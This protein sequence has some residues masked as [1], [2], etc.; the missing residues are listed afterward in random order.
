MLLTPDALQF[1][2]VKVS[3]WIMWAFLLLKQS[4]QMSEIFVACSIQEVLHYVDNS[5]QYGEDADVK[6]RDFDNEGADGADEYEWN[7][8]HRHDMQH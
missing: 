1:T 3:I 8:C 2:T 6:I 5:I 7:A 4:H